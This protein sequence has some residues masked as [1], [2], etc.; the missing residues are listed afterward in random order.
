MSPLSRMGSRLLWI[1]A[2][3][4][5]RVADLRAL[6]PPPAQRIV[7]AREHLAFLADEIGPLPACTPLEVRYGNGIR[8]VVGALAGPDPGYRQRLTVVE[9]LVHRVDA[10]VLDRMRALGAADAWAAPA[11]TGTVAYRL[12]VLTPPDRVA[13]IRTAV[14]GHTYP[15]ERRAL[16]RT[17]RTVSYGGCPISVKLALPGGTGQP[18]Y[19]DVRRAARILGVPARRI[20]D[21]LRGT[22]P[23]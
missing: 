8:L 1:D 18:E 22:A 11:L 15:V 13:A 3:P 12:T 19:D 23:G 4:R 14:P 10:A 6:D 7:A 2:G 5:A 9:A 21:D 16:A 20:L 17:E